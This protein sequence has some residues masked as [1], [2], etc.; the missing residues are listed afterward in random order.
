MQRNSWIRILMHTWLMTL[1]MQ[2]GLDVSAQLAESANKKAHRSGG[3]TFQPNTKMTLN[4]PKAESAL[5]IDG[6]IE[7]TW[8]QG[9]SFGNFVENGPVEGRQPLAETQG[10]ILFDNDYVYFAF[11]AYDPEMH[12]LRANLSDRDRIFR[13][14][15][16]GVNIDPFGAQTNGFEFF[17]N[18]L[19]IQGDLS[20]DVNEN[21]DESF[22]AV[23][24]SAAKIYD[25]RWT[26]EIAIPFKSLRFPDRQDQNWLIHLWRVYPRENRFLY[27][28]IPINRGKGNQYAQAG[29]IAMNM[30]K[31]PSKPIE[32]LPYALGSRDR[33]VKFNG[34]T[35]KGIWSKSNYDKNFGFNL[36]YGITSDM[37]LDLA[38]N[39]DFS[40]IEA[41]ATQIS[42][43]N[44]FALYYNERRPFFLEGRD[45]FF[46]DDDLN[47]MYTRSIND[48]LLLGKLSGKTDRL[49]YG[50]LLGL[51]ENAPYIVPKE[52]GSRTLLSTNNTTNNTIRAKYELAKGT[53]VGIL[54]TDRRTSD[55][56]NTV[57]TIDTKIRINDTY[58]LS[59]IVSA[60]TTDEPDATSLYGSTD[61]FVAF[62]DSLTYG[63][64]N[65]KFKG[66]A[67][68]VTLDRTAR[69]WGF[70]AWFNDRSPGFRSEQGFI[71]NNNVREAGAFSRYTF[72]MNDDHPLLTRVEPRV[73]FNRKYNY[74]GK[75]KDW[76]INPQIFLQFKKQTYFWLG[77]A[78]L[79]NENFAG[80]Q[81]N[82]IHRI[83]FESG[84]DAFQ[85]L[86][87]GLYGEVGNYINRSGNAE[88]TFNPLSK[89]KGVKLTVW[90][91]IRPISRL[92]NDFEF[93]SASFRKD[94]G[95]DLIDQQLIYR[96][97][98]QYQFTK[99]L[100]LRLI[101]EMGAINS[102]RAKRDKN[103]DDIV[104]D[105]NNQ[106]VLDKTHDVFYAISPLMSYK[107]NPFTVFYLGAN[108]MGRNNLDFPNYDGTNLN[109]TNFFLKFQYL[110]QI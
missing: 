4:V 25:D 31:R 34:D 5:I 104:L 54:G 78:A 95:G 98:L 26:V 92:R 39:P 71:T 40:Q 89:I 93:N 51:D 107:I 57:G 58:T 36:K 64:N 106:Q 62:G 24:E 50:Y 48:P 90:A 108:F 45:V 35:T 9:A 110:M 73:R 88:D 22:D 68:R 38:Y 61:R 30:E 85:K 75:L 65:E 46:V 83:S 82:N 80:K 72:Y 27:S 8:L 43:N 11:I 6:E 42:V 109:R 96:N 70:F 97:T 19:G 10:Y 56:S 81:F 102:H 41:D 2:F 63:F 20:V 94:F 79:N 100:F 33:F 84:T 77:V 3:S 52:E 1:P 76:W 105:V 21:E 23:W 53:Y 59:G 44:T 49:S 32:F 86:S 18:P 103:T 47:L 13:D 17:V 7:D 99:R 91:T 66:I 14:D 67:T 37:T 15:F 12:K 29:Q 60:S 74:D 28:W 87:G 101:G 69:E 55:G 16:V